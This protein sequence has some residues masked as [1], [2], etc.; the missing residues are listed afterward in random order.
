LRQIRTQRDIPASTESIWAVLA[1]FRRYAEWNTLNIWAD[2]QALL[3]ERVPMRFVDSG[4]GKGQVIAQ[5]VIITGL[6][7]GRYLEWTGHIPLLFTGRHF[8]ELTPLAYGTRLVHG[9]DM[10]GLIPATFS[11]KRIGRQRAAYEQLNRALEDRV[12]ALSGSA[13]SR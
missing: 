12:R 4:G 13:I 3:G 1:D 7:E 5:T 6:Q 2:G 9:E 8:F 11:N 10:S